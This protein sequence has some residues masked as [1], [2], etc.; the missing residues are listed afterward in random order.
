MTDGR[1]VVGSVQQFERTQGEMRDLSRG[2]LAQVPTRA[3][4]ELAVLDI[5][6]LNTDRHGGNMLVKP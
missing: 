5:V 4:Q 2:A 6:L 1:T 3:T